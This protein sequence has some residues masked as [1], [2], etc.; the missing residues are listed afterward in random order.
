MSRRKANKH[1]TRVAGFKLRAQVLAV[2]FVA[3]AFAIVGRGFYLQI[4][5]HQ[6][7]A[8]EGETRHVHRMSVAAHRGPIVDRRGE[9]LALSSPVD[10][11]W[12]KPTDLMTEAE[13]L[14]QLAEA[15]DLD[16]DTLLRKVNRNLD[17]HFIYLRRRALPEHVV[18]ADAL[19]LP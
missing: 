19:R 6:M 7:L 18:A 4:M 1:A 16:V 5:Q 11:I 10:S 15:L 12:A 2:F 17:K 9:P 3:S 14:P 13:R 8:T